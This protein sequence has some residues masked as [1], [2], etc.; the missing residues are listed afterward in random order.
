MSG[1]QGGVW[2]TTNICIC[3]CIC[4][5]IYTSA[6]CLY[7]LFWVVPKGGFE[8]PLLCIS[9]AQNTYTYRRTHALALTAHDVCS[10]SFCGARPRDPQACGER[11]EDQYL[12]QLDMAHLLL[13]VLSRNLYVLHK[14]SRLAA[15]H[16]LCFIMFKQV[17]LYEI[18]IDPYKSSSCQRAQ[19]NSKFGFMCLIQN[20]DSTN[21]KHI[22]SQNHMFWLKSI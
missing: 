15:D 16:S 12:N 3:I 11:M 4:I 7:I 9:H 20:P 18:N 6:S 13:E 2:I 8:S 10:A 5:I 17:Q 22:N 1:S 19:W 21:P 14:P